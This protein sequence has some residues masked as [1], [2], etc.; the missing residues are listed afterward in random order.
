MERKVGWEKGEDG[1]GREGKERER[2]TTLVEV[3]LI[4]TR[5]VLC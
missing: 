1:K 5:Q 4:R 2:R 3:D